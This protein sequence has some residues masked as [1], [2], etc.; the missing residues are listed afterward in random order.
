MK[1]NKINC[2]DHHSKWEKVKYIQQYASL[3]LRK[4]LFYEVRI[5]IKF[6]SICGKLDLRL[7]EGGGQT[8][9]PIGP[10][11][12]HINTKASELGWNNS[13]QIISKRPWSTRQESKHSKWEN[14]LDITEHFRCCCV[15]LL[16]CIPC[17]HSYSSANTSKIPKFDFLSK[18]NLLLIQ[19]PDQCSQFRSL[20]VALTPAS[21]NSEL[22]HESAM[23]GLKFRIDWNQ[24]ACSF[25][26]F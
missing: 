2:F 16:H 25:Q 6:S 9:R 1:I 22:N 12:S 7:Q 3:F 18:K 19:T 15:H 11:V 14:P 23:E 24:N 4:R 21:S 5:A 8:T 20:A 26:C 10:I 17:D 13:L